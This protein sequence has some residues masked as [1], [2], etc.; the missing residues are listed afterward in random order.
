MTAAQAKDDLGRAKERVRTKK[1]PGVA[2]KACLR[3]AFAPEA[4]CATFK[5][6]SRWLPQGPVFPSRKINLARASDRV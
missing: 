1:Q 2:P 5:T 3:V 4:L 6:V